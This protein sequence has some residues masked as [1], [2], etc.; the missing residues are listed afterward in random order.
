MPLL[1]DPLGIS[2][3][4]TSGPEEPQVVG[5]MFGLTSVVLLHQWCSQAVFSRQLKR[6]P[7]TA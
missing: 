4:I 3:I 7:T 6:F 5:G 2:R 1:G